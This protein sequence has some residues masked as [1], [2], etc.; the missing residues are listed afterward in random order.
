AMYLSDI[1]TVSVNLVGI[2]A[3]ALPCGM[4]ANGLPIGM[5]LLGRNFAE[6]NLVK[7]ANAYQT[8]TDWH[9]KRPQLKEAE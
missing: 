2:P 9:N 6:G 3:V 1:Y 4:A 7:L 8:S 5:Q